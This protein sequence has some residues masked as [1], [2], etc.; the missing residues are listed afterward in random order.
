M[1]RTSTFETRACAICGGAAAAFDVVDF[2]KSCEEVRGRFLP[3]SGKPIYYFRCPKCGFCSAPEMVSWSKERFLA[4][5]YNDDYA[6]VDPDYA[7]ERPVTN[8]RMLT[9]MFPAF[10]GRRHLDFGG[11]NGVLSQALQDSHWSSTSFDPLVD[12]GINPENLGHFDLISAFEVFEHVPDIHQVL[13]LLSSSLRAEAVLVF[14]TGLSDGEIIPNGRLTWWYA[15]PR[16]G[17]ISLFSR[18]SLEHLA[19]RY[20]F[21]FQSMKPWLH[22]FVRSALPEWAREAPSVGAAF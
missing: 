1:D 3:L 9:A 12:T 18:A 15:A 22:M 20:G 21:G 7:S 14:S 4:D 17:H 6:T 13:G 5:I 19:K 10:A 11:G 16:N 8:A 2:N